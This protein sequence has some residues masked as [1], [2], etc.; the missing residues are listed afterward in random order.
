MKTKELERIEINYDLLRIITPQGIQLKNNRVQMG[1]I[2]SRCFYI[3]DFPSNVNLSWLSSL[4]DIPN[5]T[6]S[7]LV[8]PIED[9]QAYV[10][11]IS[12]G[13]TTDR[14]V[15]NTSQNEALRTRAK[16]KIESAENIIK[17]ITV[18]NIPYVKISIVLK[19]SGDTE[20]SFNE[21]VRALKNKVAGMGLK[22]RVPAFLQEEAIKQGS[23]FAT[24]Y[25]KVKEISDKDMSLQALFGGLP[26][27]GSGLIDEE[28]YYLGT[29]QDGRM[30]A[31]SM[32]YKGNDRTNSNIVIE[33]SSGSGKSYLAKKI[34]LNEWL[35]GTRVWI[36]DP[37]SEY[38]PLCKLVEGKWID[39]SGGR[40][41]NV[42]RINPLQINS[43]DKQGD[44]DE[45]DE[46]YNV[47]KSALALHLDF[48]ST[49]FKLYYPDMTS[50]SQSLL[51]E[52]LEELYKNFGIDYDTD[53][54]NIPKEKFPIMEDLYKLLEAKTKLKDLQH[55]EEIESLRAIIRNLAIGP[56]AEIF[57][58]YTTIEFD[59]DFICL[60]LYSLQGASENVKRCQY[61]NI[62]RYCQEQAFKNRTE[63]CYVVC[64]EAYLLIDKKVPQSIEFMRNFSK[65]ARK[66]EC[67]LITITQSLIDFLAPEVKQYGQAI[68]D[69]STYKFFFGIDGKDLEEV[70]DLY[71]L[72]TDEKAVLA[73]KEKGRGLLFVGSG[74]QLIN[75]KGLEWEL[76]YLVGGGR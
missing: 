21:N 57:N 69:N 70:V 54:E 15:F 71:N 45:E 13:M 22:A 51:T 26:F 72:N 64:D 46:E 38:R 30:I 41:K 56:E 40:G 12:K 25:T 67:G 18:N 44:F 9:V 29:D 63:K 5:T 61:F 27:S 43:V 20:A 55:K 59:N 3:R 33:G 39:C 11:G 17:D 19:V 60:D 47:T 42:G 58:G 8:T 14:N 4:K 66:Y 73:Q 50:L 68:L 35:N 62:L 10:N 31:C 36:L 24:F 53:V 37:E 49:F 6:V 65:R 32:F 28:G 74:H 76:P 48:L 2:Y 1:E 23:P 52:I 34:M 16:F 7:I 75:V